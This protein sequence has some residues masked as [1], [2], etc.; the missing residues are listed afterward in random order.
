MG[1]IF[2]SVD[3]LLL[4]LV[5]FEIV[6]AVAL[7]KFLFWS[8]LFIFY[9]FLHKM[10]SF[11]LICTNTERKFPLLFVSFV[12]SSTNE[13][14]SLFSNRY[15][16]FLFV[17]FT[18]YFLDFSDYLNLCIFFL[19]SLFSLEETTIIKQKK[20]NIFHFA[21]DKTNEHDPKTHVM[22]ID[23]SKNKKK[24][25]Q[26]TGDEKKMHKKSIGKRTRFP[27]SS[28]IRLVAKRRQNI[29]FTINN[30][31]FFCIVDLIPRGF[32]TI[33]INWPRVLSKNLI[34]NSPLGF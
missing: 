21:H 17:C 8:S 19:C 29:Y 27:L 5:F 4:L 23:F 14:E 15:F 6:P 7:F 13:L 2:V 34:T 20:I 18:S 3:V 24:A 28:R 10:F 26:R 33:V 22:M 12:S 32:L 16:D 31:F 1:C 25:A 9:K 11:F 30:R